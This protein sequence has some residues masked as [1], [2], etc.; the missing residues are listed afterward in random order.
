MEKKEN[1]HAGHRQRKK[2]Q[3][4]D[5]DLEA[6][7]PHEALELLLYYAIP[8][9]DTNGIAHALLNRFGSLNGVFSAPVTDLQQVSGVG[10][11]AALLLHLVPQIYRRSLTDLDKP[12]QVIATPDDAGE[13]L[14]KYFWSERNEIVLEV[15]VDGKFRL[16]ACHKLSEGGA[17]GSAFNLRDA[18]RYALSD[19]AM[20]VYLAHNH[21]SGLAL[22]SQADVEVTKMVQKSLEAVGIRLLDHLII[23][24][25]DFTSMAASGILQ[26]W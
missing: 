18:V 12:G 22:P 5:H 9:A 6:F 4:L 25:N 14:K 7:A 17:A 2:Q 11:S 16:L 13:F 3:F 23:A 8:R 15:C 19:N 26:G 21:P 10:E 1:P 24:E 20:Y